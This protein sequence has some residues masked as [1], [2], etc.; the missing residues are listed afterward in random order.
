MNKV[1]SSYADLPLW[2]HQRDALNVV[3]RYLAA[4][5]ESGGSA[6]LIRMPTGTGKSGVI[7]AATQLLVAS[8]DS[9]VLSPWDALV[10]QLGRDIA[11]RFWNRISVEPPLGRRTARLFPSTAVDELA[12]TRIPAI[13]TATIATLQQLRRDA[14]SAYAE[15]ARR[16]SLVI[17]DEGHY[18]PA[19][20]WALAVR[21]LTRPTVLFTAT[22]YRNDFKF[23][24]IDADYYFHLSHADAERERYLRKVRFAAVSYQY[25]AIAFCDA[26]VATM[27]EIE[28]RA[29][30]ARAIVRCASKGTVQEVAA[31]LA[32]RHE[33][34]IGVHERFPTGDNVLRQH[35]PNPETETARYW[36]HQNKLT[37]GIDDPAFRLVAFFEPFRSER[38]L[39]QQIGRVLR[40][41]SRRSGQYAVV[42]HDPRDG[43]EE[44]WTAYSRYDEMH[45]PHELLRS[46]RE[47]ATLQP[48]VQ[49]V[50][51]RFRERFDLASETVHLDFDYPLSTRIY[52]V[53]A[54][55][56]LDQL[57]DAVVRLLDESDFDVGPTRSPTPSTRLHPYVAVRNSPLLWRKAF[58]EFEIGFTVYHRLRD[59]LF[60]YDSQG[61]VPPSSNSMSIID[62]AGL[63]RLY[64]ANTTRLTTV[65]LLNTDL[66]RNSVRRRTLR[67]RSIAELGP[68]LSDHAQFA[69]TARGITA[70]TGGDAVDRYVGFTRSRVRDRR[71]GVTS[72]DDYLEWLESIADVIDNTSTSRAAVFDRFAEVISAPRDPTPRNILLDFP[73]ERF[74]AIIDEVDQELN[75]DDVCVEVA[76][77]TFT[78]RANDVDHEVR[79]TWTGK[80]YHLESPTLDDLYSMHEPGSDRHDTLISHLNREQAFRVL[81]ASMHDDHCVYVGGTFIRPRL[82]LWGRLETSRFELLGILNPIEELGAIGDE[83]GRDGSATSSGWAAGSLFHLIDNL[84]AGTQLA[85]QLANVDLLVCDDM[86]TEIADFVALD[87]TTGRVIAIH[88]KA[89]RT[90]KPRSA[91]A[92]H[93]VSSQALK[94]LAYL[95]PYFVGEPKNLNHW[96]GPWKG[97]AGV[98][99]KRV[100]RGGQLTAKQAWTRFRSA[101]RDPSTTREVWL[102][103][104]QGPSKSQL[105]HERGKQKP[106]PEVIQML[107]S[108][109]ATWAAVSAVG[110]RLRVFCSP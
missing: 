67:A 12:A 92:L 35:V 34:V 110:A 55:F 23:F 66:G 40:N 95:Q 78:F 72:F 65:T 109:Q 54:D 46:P 27:R 103:L 70:A 96:S 83:K 81:P 51:G 73:V 74:H 2:P 64:G 42:L 43:L 30:D 13:W 29:P 108:L 37:E 6:A 39:V 57:A 68:D 80:S 47:F 69:S 101:L 56:S 58:A 26:V 7:A 99:A 28:A 8:G 107:F 79:I 25:S 14:A 18:E 89:F 60:F 19:L 102:V 63:Q 94:N 105:D 20:E 97:P 33:T 32:R 91:S 5:G 31:E 104:G 3:D 106:K 98:V 88:A 4:R 76:D 48:S 1:R 90:A 49:Y 9:L 10:D 61:L 16:V 22:P 38:A 24:D 93:E 59:Y 87:T 44:S 53:S 36:V 84:G 71:A 45:D 17:V 100:R 62:A 41:P 77:G 86:G 75:I 85:P 52:R 50:T 82:P 15:L 11:E 21:N